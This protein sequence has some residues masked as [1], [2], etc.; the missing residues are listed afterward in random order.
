MIAPREGAGV[1]PPRMVK[2][3][4]CRQCGAALSIPADPRVFE[5]RCHYC[6]LGQPVPDAAE[7]RREL[8][9]NAFQQRIQADIEGAQRSARRTSKLMMIPGLVI[10]AVCLVAG[11]AP[12][13][14]MSFGDLFA[15]SWDGTEP[16]DCDGNDQKTIEGVVAHLPGTAIYARG[17]CHL[18]LERCEI[19][20]ATAIEASGNAQVTIR[21]GSIDAPQLADVSGNARVD[22][23]GARVRGKVRRTD[24]G[25][26]TGIP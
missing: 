17:N 7:R 25:R 10:A 26:V 2:V 8:E 21:G 4:D 11:L 16:F 13:L 14:K 15:P 12:V 22:N 18:T 24:N 6:G 3:L 23:R 19:T 9:Q 5:V 1:Y 20:A